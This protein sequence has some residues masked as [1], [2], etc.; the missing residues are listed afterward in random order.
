MKK[1]VCI[2]LI[3]GKDNTLIKENID[4]LNDI[5]FINELII[6]NNSSSME[7]LN[8]LFPKK[9]TF[10]IKFL[11]L[12]NNNNIVEGINNALRNSNSAYSLVL[13]DYQNL[14]SQA[15]LNI[16]NFFD[17]NNSTKIICTNSIYT[18]IKG[19]FLSLY[20]VGN[21]DNYSDEKNYLKPFNN[22]AVVFRNK[23]F[24]IIGEFD[25]KL[26]YH[27]I[28]EYIMRCLK[29]N[30]KFVRFESCILSKSV[31]TNHSTIDGFVDLKSAFEFLSINNKFKN[32]KT[33]Y[34]EK[35][36]S[37]LIYK[38]DYRE[39]NKIIK[40][41]QLLNITREKIESL[42]K[43]VNYEFQHGDKYKIIAEDKPK[44]LKLILNSRWDLQ[45]NNLH[46]QDNERK[47]C[48]W[49]IKHGFNEYPALLNNEDSKET[50]DWLYEKHSKDSIS[51]LYRAIWDS[52]KFF[53]KI[54]RTNNSLKLFDLFIKL[55]WNFLPYKLPNK[56]KYKFFRKIKFH[57]SKFKNF[58]QPKKGVNLIGYAKHALG[59]GE[60]LRSTAFAIKSMQ[61]ETAIINF[62]P[63]SF[64]GR[65][66]KTLKKLIQK[67]HSYKTTILCLTAEETLRYV[68]REGSKNLK[69][70]Y[71]IGYWPWELP[72]WPKS[73]LFALDY[74]NEIWV[75]SKHIKDA[76]SIETDKPIKIMPLC[77]DQEGFQLRQENNKEREQNRK[78]FNLDLNSIYICYSFDQNSYI[79]RKNPLDAFRAFQIA[80]PPYPA[81][82][83][84]KNVKLII[85]TFPN[86]N[87]S[88][89]WQYLKEMTKFDERVEIVEMNMNR[90]ELMQFYGCCDIFLSLHRAEGYG[91]CLA[92][93][94]QLGLDLIATDWSGNKDFCKGSLYHPVP[95]ELMPVKPFEY[96]YWQE[97]FWAE[98][99][100][101][102]AAKILIKVVS[103][104]K[105]EGIP[106]QEISKEY[107]RYFSA[108]TCGER[109]KKRLE[110]L[111]LFNAN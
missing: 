96:P 87:I 40:N 34:I 55:F 70:K 47:L 91:R 52:S 8:N 7:K 73:W 19:N 53:R 83:M 50:I 30:S 22:S 77:V 42:F 97:Q 99:D 41:K 107:Q 45:N 54:F 20:P 68:M 26:S 49:L 46:L 12:E 98:P 64:K 59:I 62:S 33:S 15:L 90:I 109:Y 27:F 10:E 5:D 21:K 86:K 66:E 74:V 67:K 11:N 100:I 104:R 9:L 103:K 48:C 23:I 57:I 79:D 65:E 14:H 101:N 16:V 82:L 108:K 89:E 36:I 78:K 4:S 17:Q 58:D 69:G 75:S 31:V 81:N 61:L 18:D 95:Y 80:F 3:I 106:N 6:I 28:S 24:R 25:T 84:D 88:W 43:S 71:V 44:Q 111:N 105:R 60:D 51:R 37:Q 56:K 38:K 32:K 39:I 110:E 35:K 72:K 102:E 94:L 13:N 29:F 63:G 76:I 1:S 92:E 2:V 85:K 93:A